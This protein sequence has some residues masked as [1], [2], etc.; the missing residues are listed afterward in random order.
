MN[1]K[2]HI[3]MGI[4]FA[5]ITI[6]IFWQS[7]IKDFSYLTLFTIILVPVYALLP[8]IDHKSSKITWVFLTLSALLLV[9]GVGLSQ[10]IAMFFGLGLFV[11]TLVSVFIFKHRGLTHSITFGLL[12]S[13]PIFYF[14]GITAFFLCFV[15]YYSHLACDGLILKWK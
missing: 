2:W 8:D 15:A 5:L 9:I 13:L 6:A 4:L 14:L 3:T 12:V 10:Q 1:W 11:L 7:L